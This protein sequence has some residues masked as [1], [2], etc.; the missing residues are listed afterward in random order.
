VTRADPNMQTTQLRDA[1][2]L[3]LRHVLDAFGRDIAVAIPG[4]IHRVEVPLS[5]VYELV[6][7]LTFSRA[8][9]PEEEVV[10]VSLE[11]RD[12]TWSMDMTDRDSITIEE[13][14]PG[15]DMSTV[16]TAAGGVESLIEKWRP[17]IVSELSQ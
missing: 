3:R 15:I 10:A 4:T 17:R 6:A 8:D 16:D 13:E 14:E 11:L 7:V 1:L 9:D 12:G 5:R 2:R